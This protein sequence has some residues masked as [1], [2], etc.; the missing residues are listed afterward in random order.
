MHGFNWFD[1]RGADGIPLLR[2]LRGRL[3]SNLP[4]FL[5]ATRLGNSAIFDEMFEENEEKRPCIN[6]MVLET[7]AH[8]N[9]LAFFGKDLGM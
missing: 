1:E 7:V 3:T 6:D 9:A 5:P 8:T 4:H 2:T